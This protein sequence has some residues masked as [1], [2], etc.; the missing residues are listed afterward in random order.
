MQFQPGTPLL[1]CAF[2]GSSFPI[3][4]EQAKDIE[5]PQPESIVPAKLDRKQFMEATYR[6][7]SSGYFTK[8]DLLEM[9]RINDVIGTYLPFYGFAVDFDAHYTASAG[10]NYKVTERDSQ[11]K[12]KTVTKTRWEPVTGN[13]RGIVD[14]SECTCLASKQLEGKLTDFIEELDWAAMTSFD[15]RYMTGFALEAFGSD[16]A[17]VW[18]RQGDKK[19]EGVIEKRISKLIP[20]DSHKDL[21][22]SARKQWKAKRLYAPLWLANY[23]Y[24]GTKNRI[25]L[26]ASRGRIS[27]DRPKDVGRIIL[28]VLFW[29]IGIGAAYFLH[30]KAPQSYQWLFGLAGSLVVNIGHYGW[31]VSAKKGKLKKLHGLEQK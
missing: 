15:A 5:V 31:N 23:D 12:M 6:Y 24:K 25:A 17:A 16:E 7:L 3:K 2:C 19:S 8:D 22:F 28:V 20:G 21:H 26:E 18:Q 29:L 14:P 4:P 1:V 30:V 27:G 11:G 10:Y 13:L 9:A